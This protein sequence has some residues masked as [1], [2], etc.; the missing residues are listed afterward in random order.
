M[1]NSGGLGGSCAGPIGRAAATPHPQPLPGAISAVVHAVLGS[2]LASWWRRNET[3]RTKQH[4][5]LKHVI[6]VQRNRKQ[7]N[8]GKDVD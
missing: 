3:K 5:R 2:L 7:I 8:Y 6:E 1:Q 4:K